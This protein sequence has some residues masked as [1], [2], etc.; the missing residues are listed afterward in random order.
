[1][2]IK[3]KNILFIFWVFCLIIFGDKLSSEE[4]DISASEITF[5]KENQIVTGKGSVVVTDNTGKTIKSEK[6][7]L[8]S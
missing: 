8:V 6:A 7:L 4:F 2:Q 1:M 5:D 3:S